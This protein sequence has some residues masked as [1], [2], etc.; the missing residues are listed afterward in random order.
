MATS[1]MFHVSVALLLSLTIV[2]G[3][4]V[5]ADLT[6]RSYSYPKGETF[7]FTV[8]ENFK[9]F[10]MCFATSVLVLRFETKITRMLT[11]CNSSLMKIPSFS[12]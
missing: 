3:A 12:L 8:A 11:R 9:K 7:R 2:G 1:K 6:E 5:G 4:E 10:G